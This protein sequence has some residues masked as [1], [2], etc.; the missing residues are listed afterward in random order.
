MDV[1]QAGP[2][3]IV[4]HWEEKVLINSLTQVHVTP[5]NKKTQ[6]KSSS[7]E[8]GRGAG[9]PGAMNIRR[10]KQPSVAVFRNAV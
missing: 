5:K 1:L 9:N 2:D 6:I 4:F 10:K 7:G 8:A 3:R